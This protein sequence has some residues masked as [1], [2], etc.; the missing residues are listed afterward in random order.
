MKISTISRP[1]INF[2]VSHE[3]IDI[4][5]TV[6]FIGVSAHR[7][8]EIKNITNIKWHNHKGIIEKGVLVAEIH[9]A[10][11]IIPIHAPLNCKFLGQNQ[12]LAGN[13]NLI[14][15]SPQDHGWVFFVTPLK[16]SHQEPLLSPESYQKLIQTKVAN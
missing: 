3:W 2:T 1:R 7:L 6:G 10:D 11:Q 15:E 5:G 4:N 14:I 16:F 12:K 13:L 8:K 9:T